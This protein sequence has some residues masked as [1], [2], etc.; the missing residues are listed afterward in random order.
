MSKTSSNI[1]FYATHTVRF[2]TVNIFFNSCTSW[3]NIHIYR[4]I[5]KSR[6]TW[7]CIVIIRCT[8]T[9]WSSCIKKFLHVS[10]PR[11]YPQGVTSFVTPWG[12][13][14]DAETCKTYLY[15]LCVL[16]CTVH[17]LE[18]ILIQEYIDTGIYWYRNILIQE[19]IDTGISSPSA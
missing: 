3:Y 10:A 17:L 16:Y 13:H 5:K 18:N 4:V 8:E 1:Q 19:Y 12:W 7:D 2:P 9:F 11:C 14:V 15:M 6:C